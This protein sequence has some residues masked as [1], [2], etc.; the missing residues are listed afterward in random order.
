LHSN[1]RH[2]LLFTSS[3]VIFWKRARTCAPSNCLLG[4]RNLKT[5]AIYLHV[6]TLA[7]RSTAS[8]LDLHGTIFSVEATT[9]V[10]R[11]H[12]ELADVFKALDSDS[13]KNDTAS[14]SSQQ[15]RAFRH[16]Q[17]SHRDAHRCLSRFEQ[18][19]L[20]CNF[21]CH[22]NTRVIE[23]PPCARELV[24]AQPFASVYC[25]T[26]TEMSSQIAGSAPGCNL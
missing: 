16:H 25:S 21:P 14:L 22:E 11:P 23:C 10:T 17:V 1:L 8:P 20:H 3:S 4:H 19:T 9:T 5:T 18:W 6:S 24:R 2:T 13:A 12:L 7:L 15:R 26:N